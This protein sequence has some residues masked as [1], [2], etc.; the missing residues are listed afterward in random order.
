M[1]VG[2]RWCVVVVGVVGCIAF[3]YSVCV[4]TLNLN[5][6][7]NPSGLLLISSELP[8]TPD[9]QFNLHKCLRSIRVDFDGTST[10]EPFQN[11]SSSWK[12]GFTVWRNKRFC[13]GN[14]VNRGFRSIRDL[15]IFENKKF[16]LIGCSLTRRTFIAFKAVLE[17]K[18]FGLDERRLTDSLSFHD[19][20]LNITFNTVFAINPSDIFEK[21]LS[22]NTLRLLEEADMVYMETGTWDSVFANSLLSAN[23]KYHELGKIFTRNIGSQ[24]LNYSMAVVSNHTHLFPEWT[25]TRYGSKSKEHR[26]HIWSSNVQSRLYREYS[27]IFKKLPEN[28]IFRRHLN[29][30]TIV[31]RSG[32]ADSRPGVNMFLIWMDRMM[33]ISSSGYPFLSG[34]DNTYDWN[35]S[36]R[37]RCYP[38]ECTYDG[39]A[40]Y[41]HMNPF[42]TR[43]DTELIFAALEEAFLHVS[44]RKPSGR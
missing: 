28:L 18:K 17:G 20:K 36:L 13:R 40:C 1:G 34:M 11:D 21:I 39:T 8:S 19:S 41:L 37:H 43:V 24:R 27:D 29:S 44:S 9:V 23:P 2:R 14:G 10:P 5:E 16:L 30:G 33:E 26:F 38:K 12:C 22:A 32:I 3:V 4:G 35:T 31:L 15:K 7:S 6:Y 25:R 42:G